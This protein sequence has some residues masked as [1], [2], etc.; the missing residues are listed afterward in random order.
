MEQYM[1]YCVRCKKKVTIENPQEVTLKNGK[2]AIK[3][4]CPYCKGAVFV[5]VKAKVAQ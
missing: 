3:G 1:G 5:F 4:T 2:K